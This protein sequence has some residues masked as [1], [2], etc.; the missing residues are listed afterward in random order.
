MFL[1]YDFHPVPQGLGLIEVNINAGGAMLNAV[2]GRAHRA[3]C[4]EVERLGPSVAR[5]EGFENAIVAMF[6]NEW[7]LSGRS[8]PLRT[9]A[10]VD[11]A[12]RQQYLYAEF[13]LFQRLFERHGLR[14]W[15][16]DPA[17]FEWK[18]GGLFLRGVLAH[19]SY[20]KTAIQCHFWHNPSIQEPA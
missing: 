2:L 15:I 17:E 1:G 10:I 8:Q 19:G 7:R 9:L 12:P 11:D 18:A 4:A 14:A 16:A 3:C 20:W 5:A 6:H 13:L